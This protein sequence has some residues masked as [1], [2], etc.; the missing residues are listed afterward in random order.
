MQIYVGN[1]D[2]NITEEELRQHCLQFGEIDYVKI[3][4]SKG[5]GF[6]QFA[7][8]Q[9]IYELNRFSLCLKTGTIISTYAGY[10]RVVFLYCLTCQSPENGVV[11]RTSAEEAIQKLQGVMIGL[12][13]VRVFWGRK[14][15]IFLRKNFSIFVLY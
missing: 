15:V 4:A 8:R 5:C 1:L 6:V 12:Q 3:P 14:Q 13:V 9:V 10:T 11:S 2:P 7:T